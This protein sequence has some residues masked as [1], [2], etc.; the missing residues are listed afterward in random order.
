[1]TQ[2]FL[3]LSAFVLFVSILVDTPRSLAATND[4]V[5][6]VGDI[7]SRAIAAMRNGDTAAANQKRFRELFHQYFDVE[8][9]PVLLSG[10]IGVPRPRSSSMSSS[11]RLLR[12][13][14]SSRPRYDHSFPIGLA[15]QHRG[16]H[17]REGRFGKRPLRSTDGRAVV[18]HVAQVGSRSMAVRR[19]GSIG[20][21]T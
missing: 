10:H 9:A 13:D 21:S 16:R 6:I 15:P 7:G 20:D 1:M 5:S 8:A 3:L 11:N 18:S 14:V 19:A 4:P 2:R 17:A 12:S